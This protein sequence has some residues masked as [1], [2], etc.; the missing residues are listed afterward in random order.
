M[1]I[2]YRFGPFTIDCQ[3]QRLLGGEQPL[4][5]TARTFDLLLALVQRRGQL[6]SKDELL[7]IVWGD[8]AVTEANLTQQIFVLRRLL[9]E[10]NHF[11]VTVPRRGYRFVATVVENSGHAPPTPAAAAHLKARY[12]M[13][14][15]TPGGFTQA[16]RYLNRA[17]GY[18]PLYAPAYADLAHCHALDAATSLPRADRMALAKAAALK[19]L[20]LDDALA[21]AHAALASIAARGDWD[22]PPAERHFQRAIALDPAS[23]AVRH[24]YAL[25]LCWMG[26]FAEAIDEMRRAAALDRLSPVASVG[27]GRVLDLA[28]RHA[29]AVLE[30]ERALEVDPEYAEGYFDMAMA[31]RHCGRHGE[32]LAADLEA[33]ALAPDKPAYRGGLAASYAITG[34]RADAEQEINSLIALSRRSYV[35]P[36][37]LA[38]AALTLG[39]VEGALTHLEGAVA[40]RSVETLYLAV[41]PDCQPLAGHPRFQALLARIGLPPSARRF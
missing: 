27:T 39:D 34:R 17:I 29:E 31:L 32:A 19:A 9:D 38:F 5:L 4:P 41:D 36:V 8:V 26:R 6:V 33:V 16:I 15:R 1:S 35:S 37:V 25:F 7:R 12:Y 20:E 21:E 24:G 11:I 18:D 23:A 2:E 10:Q 13:S 14:R 40:E 30:Y 28:G 22:W 3:R